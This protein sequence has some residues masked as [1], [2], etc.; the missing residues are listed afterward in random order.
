LAD[1]F[2][3]E[4]TDLCKKITQTY[5]KKLLF[6]Q[7]EDIHSNF[8]AGIHYAAFVCFAGQRTT[9]NDTTR[10]NGGPTGWAGGYHIWGGVLLV[11]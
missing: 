3:A 7:D 4:S 10:V 5:S 6:T 11:R 2:C 9:K 8:P 1:I